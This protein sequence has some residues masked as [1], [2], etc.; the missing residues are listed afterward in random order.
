MRD[1]Y[2]FIAAGGRPGDPKPPAF[3][4]FEDGYHAAVVVE[5]VLDSHRRGGV[6]T[7]VPSLIG[8]TG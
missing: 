3:A 8:A 2:G 4:T 1:V 7:R 6:W 5:A